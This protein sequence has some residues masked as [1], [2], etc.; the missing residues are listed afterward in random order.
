MNRNKILNVLTIAFL[1]ATF[2]LTAIVFR[3]LPAIVPMHWNIRGEVDG[4]GPRGTVWITPGIQVF[5]TIL[6]QGLTYAL[7]K[8]EKQR[9]AFA[10]MGFGMAA[11]FLMLQ[12]MILAAGMNYRVDMTRWMGFG[13]SLMF[14]LFGLAMKDLPRNG[15]AGI[16]LPWTM[17]SDE[18]WRLTHQRAARFVTIGSGLGAAIS[19]INGFAGILISI[20]AMLY[21]LPDSYFATRHLS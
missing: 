4:Y 16:R 21:T 10:L 19:L 20:L 1:L 11:F 15:L 5:I 9:F 8:D 18:A 2:V 7:A 17:K 12:C 3:Q 14:M 13:L 6:F